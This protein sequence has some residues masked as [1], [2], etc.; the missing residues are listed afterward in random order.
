MKEGAIIG[1][2]LSKKYPYVVGGDFAFL[3]TVFTPHVSYSKLV[4]GFPNLKF[5]DYNVV[6]KLKNQLNYRKQYFSDVRKEMVN[7]IK[8]FVSSKFIPTNLDKHR[9][10]LGNYFIYK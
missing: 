10:Y 1:F 9:L 6:G 7:E 2:Y 8:F 5:Y 3:S 4:E